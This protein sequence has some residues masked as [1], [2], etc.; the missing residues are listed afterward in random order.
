MHTKEFKV[1]GAKVK[2]IV[3]TPCRLDF[4]VD[5]RLV[6]FVLHNIFQ[7]I[8]GGYRILP[9][10]SAEDGRNLIAEW[11]VNDC[12][13]ATHLL[14]MDSDTAPKDLYA[15]QKLLS[16]NKPVVA[17][18]TPIYYKQG[19]SASN[20]KVVD[21]FA[22]SM[23]WNI[24]MNP[25]NDGGNGNAI[26]LDELPDKPFKASCFGGTTILI[27]R[28]VME[29]I[30][31]PYYRVVRDPATDTII[32]GEDYYFARKIKEAG[33]DL[34]VDPTVVCHHS[35]INDLLEMRDLINREKESA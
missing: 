34:W 7:G 11:F 5:A 32:C 35:Q 28:K 2:V 23:V 26:K 18:V 10:R 27:Q 25:S 13:D 9:S 6:T 19:G 14:W 30:K 4:N 15:L 33:F 1:N 16:H 17:G 8:V 22:G 3:G 20:T 12:K 21:Q 24:L 29:A 31:P